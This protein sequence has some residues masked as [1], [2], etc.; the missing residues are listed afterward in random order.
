[1]TYPGMLVQFGVTSNLKVER[2]V[3]TEHQSCSGGPMVYEVTC[4]IEGPVSEVHACLDQCRKLY[5]EDRIDTFAVSPNRTWSRVDMPAMER[6]SIELR[7][8]R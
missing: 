4:D 2:L 3:Y 8:T 6:V 7:W 1:M 5:L